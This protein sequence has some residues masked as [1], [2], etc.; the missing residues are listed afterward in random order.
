MSK[1]SHADLPASGGQ[2]FRLAPILLAV[3][4]VAAV[5]AACS[6]AGPAGGGQAAGSTPTKP[7]RATFTP[8]PGALATPVGGLVVR[9]TLPPGVTAESGGSAVMP[10]TTTNALGTPEVVA[11][12][13]ET[14]LLLYAT[15]TPTSSPTPTRRPPTS[16]PIESIAAEAPG[17]EPTPYVVIKPA[18]LNGRRGPG[19]EYEKV[20]Q[21]KQGQQL[22]VLA[23][24]ADGKW[25]Q[26]CCLANQPVWVS[27]DQ[28]ESNGEVQGAAVLTP[29]PPPLPTPTRRPVVAAPRSGQSPV[30]T[31][32]PAGTPLPP[33]DIARGPEWG[34]TEN[35]IMTIWAKVF[36][37]PTDNQTPLGGYVL[38]VFRDGV[39]VSSNAQSV[40][41]APFNNTGKFQGNRD[42]NLK[43]E[44]NDAS[45]SDYEIYLARPGG[46]RVSPITKF[47]TKGTSYRTLVVYMA[48]WLAR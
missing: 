45:E 9:G 11:S 22:F 3:F 41:D 43:F 38:K 40:G 31:P 28:V 48:Y 47:T 44:L 8:L 24:T 27:A 1:M 21:A 35:G 33:F 18:T 30:A 2:R 20:G 17:A 25:L 42:Y 10:Y 19:T 46:F 36:E 14:N 7:R 16:T 29:P 39:D 6:A 4:L 12:T 26:V 13:G 5:S 23:R 32:R 37:G 15:D 34:T